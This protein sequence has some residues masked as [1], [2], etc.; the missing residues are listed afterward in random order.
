MSEGV[1]GGVGGGGLGQC[2]YRI[3]ITAH[4]S[5]V[6]AAATSTGR[7][8]CAPANEGSGGVPTKEEGQEAVDPIKRVPNVKKV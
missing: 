2:S 6:K 8:G 5:E 4:A 1:T 7:V 3:P